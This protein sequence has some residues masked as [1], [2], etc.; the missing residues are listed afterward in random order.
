MPL[1]KA[2]IGHSISGA[3]LY[4]MY[5][6]LF[7]QE[8]QKSE[9]SNL[10]Q[11]ISYLWRGE[12]L[13]LFGEWISPLE[14]DVSFSPVMEPVIIRNMAEASKQLW[15]WLEYGKS[16]QDAVYDWTKKSVVI[17]GQID[18][19]ATNY[20][21][22]NVALFKKVKSLEKQFRQFKGSTYKKSNVLS[23]SERQIFYK[24]LRDAIYFGT[25]EDIA[26]NYYAAYNYLLN[27][28]ERDG[29]VSK[30]AREKYAKR[31]LKSVIKHMQ[32][33]SLSVDVRGRMTS[34]KE[35]FRR[36]LSPAHKLLLDKLDKHHSYRLRRLD[37]I[38]NNLYWKNKLSVYPS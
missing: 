38:I 28:Q 20:R 29:V 35:E 30:K 1:V 26:K 27:V 8:P 6:A 14:R 9:S 5:K 18:K 36:F 7:N 2:I 17:V 23:T 25:D 21:N 12:A 4:G 16:L 10:D 13:G 33:T 3:A 37:K 19:V 11:A 32:P 34:K 31:A 24:D 22:P 15:Q